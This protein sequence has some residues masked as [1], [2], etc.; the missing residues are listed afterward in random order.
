MTQLSD[1]FEEHRHDFKQSIDEDPT[2]KG[3]VRE[4]QSF[5][6][7]HFAEYRAGEALDLDRAGLVELLKDLMKGESQ[8]TLSMELRFCARITEGTSKM[9]LALI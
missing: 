2:P 4:A 5:L 9:R 3:V 6:N 1:I 8:N 7:I